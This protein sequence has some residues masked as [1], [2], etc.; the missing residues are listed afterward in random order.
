[1]KFFHTSNEFHLLVT[2]NG[3]RANNQQ[4]G[5]LVGQNVGQNN[6]KNPFLCMEGLVTCAQATIRTSFVLLQTR[7]YTY[8]YTCLVSVPF[9]K[10]SAQMYVQCLLKS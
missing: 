7:T 10:K 1:M 6:G 8:I 3:V 4:R 5:D 9:I 2:Y